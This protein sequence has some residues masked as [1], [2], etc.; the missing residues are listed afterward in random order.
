MKKS[1]CTTLA[2]VLTLF[3]KQGASAATF[4][5]TS[6]SCGTESG[7]FRWALAQANSTPGLDTIDIQPGLAIDMSANGGSCGLLGT[8]RGTITESVQIEANGATFAGRQRYFANDGTLLNK[9]C[10]RFTPNTAFSESFG[11]L[12]IGESN[13]SA[14]QNKY[15]YVNQ[16]DE[17]IILACNPVI[18]PEYYTKPTD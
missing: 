5:V 14:L 18:Y 8:Y 2:L 4:N 3:V 9:A 15:P 7:T 1:I 10:P 6:N 12:Q 13:K 16:W 17:C 11:L